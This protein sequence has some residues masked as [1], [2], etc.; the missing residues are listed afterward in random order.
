MRRLGLPLLFLITMDGGAQKPAPTAPA[1]ASA[2][3]IE[4][5][6]PALDAASDLI[7]RALFLRCFCA[8]NNLQ[9]DTQGKPTGQIKTVDWTLAGVNVQKAER[10]DA[11]TIQ[12]EGVRVAI[13][14]ATDRREFDRHP[15]NDE[16]VRILLADPGN[17][18]AFQSALKTIFSV[19]IDR[20]L[21]HS[22]PDFWQH[23][24]EPT[25]DWQ[26]DLKGQTIYTPGTPG[27]PAGL[28]GPTQTHKADA[29]YSEPAT[30]DR[31]QGTLTLRMIV[32]TNGSPRRVT[33][34]QP[35]GYGLDARAAEAA[36]K[37]RFAPGM[38][39]GIPVDESIVINQQFELVPVPGR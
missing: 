2:V 28:A 29:G 20:T 15:L 3:P 23:Y 13:R 10:K 21:Q 26:D 7:G 25:K 14:Y 16:K 9:F 37:F 1:M 4:R 19:G 39:N 6:D 11:N 17:P 38:L 32:D 5:R 34:V 33:V 31:V 12:L 8:E 30:H 27:T 36:E 22:M 24:F 18:A 35:L